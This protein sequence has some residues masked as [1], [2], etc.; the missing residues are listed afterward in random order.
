MGIRCLLF[1][2][3]LP[4][5]H[6]RR[7]PSGCRSGLPAA[8]LC[9]RPQCW[10]ALAGKKQLPSHACTCNSQNL[11]SALIILLP[12]R[13][14]GIDYAT[15]GCILTA[16]TPLFL[17]LIMLRARSCNV[18]LQCRVIKA[19]FTFAL[20]LEALTCLGGL[21]MQSAVSIASQQ[22]VLLYLCA[23]PCTPAV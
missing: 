18:S 9:S 15:Q 5:C 22:T 13:S 6:P 8:R 4:S 14:Q 1:Q 19:D 3:D 23:L 16:A 10:G 12:E 17:L 20:K 7:E 2:G 11:Q 21:W